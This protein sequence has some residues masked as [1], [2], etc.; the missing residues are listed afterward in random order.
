MVLFAWIV[1]AVLM[2]IFC[3]WMVFVFAIAA[4]VW[5]VIV[6][7]AFLLTHLLVTAISLF[8]VVVVFFIIVNAG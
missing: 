6:F 2:C 8:C 7:A 1:F 3:P 4:A 5:L